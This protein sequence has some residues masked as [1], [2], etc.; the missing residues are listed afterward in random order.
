[1]GPVLTGISGAAVVLGSLAIVPAAAAAVPGNVGA[2][3]SPATSV[4]SAAAEEKQKIVPV[5]VRVSPGRGVYGV[6]QL[7]TASF[8]H[9]IVRKADVEQA[10][11]V[12]SDRPVSVGAWGW[13][14]DRTAVYRPKRFWPANARIAFRLRLHKVV[15]AR[16]G[17]TKYVGG[18][19]ADKT[20]VLRTGRSLVMT[21]RDGTHR[22]YVDRNGRRVK[23]FP[24]SLGK[25]GYQTRSGIKILT[26]E[27]YRALRM[28]GVDRFT[29][30]AWDVVSPYSIRL[31]PSGEYLHGA[32]WAYSRLGRWN[33]SHGCTNMYTSDARWLFNHVIAGDP[34]VTRGTGREMET[35]NGSPGAYWNYGWGD[36]KRMSGKA[37]E[38]R[39][40]RKVSSA[41]RVPVVDGP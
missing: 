3:A 33:G 9:R 38:R 41:V 24:V 18:R 36:W 27:K 17:D 16:A 39:D 19:Q 20:H 28:T 7:V 29:G 31:T 2:L 23:T 10:I 1:M 5:Q 13:I 25:P 14:D 15:V 37:A 40:A 35:W 8:S 22:M 11:T 26:G 32:P 4:S 30:E 21:I 12:T 34:V 6:G